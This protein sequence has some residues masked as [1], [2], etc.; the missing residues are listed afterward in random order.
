MMPSIPPPDTWRWLLRLFGPP[1]IT[2]REFYGDRSG[3]DTFDHGALDDL[4][5]RC[6]DDGGFVDYAGLARY[7]GLLD[8]YLSRIAIVD[9][10]SLSRDEKLALLINTYNAATLRLILDHMP[11]ASIQDIPAKARWKARRWTVGGRTLSLAD[12]ENQELRARFDE[13]RIHFAINCASVGCPRLRNGA[14]TGAAID[15]ELAAHT[16]IIHA[17]ARW[18]HRTPDGFHLTRI[19]RW[20]EGDFIQ[21][22]GTAEKYAARFAPEIRKIP[23]R[24]WLPYDWSLNAA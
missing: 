23:C 12:I 3:K 13:P 2:M 5:R 8:G 11:I 17:D 19:Y 4:L 20:Y 14:F 24:G 6:V 15:A 10:D 22:A 21:S 9:F 18:L 1:R 16:R 7:A